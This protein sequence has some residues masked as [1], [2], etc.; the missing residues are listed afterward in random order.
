[1]SHTTYYLGHTT[2]YLGTDDEDWWVIECSCGFRTAG[3]PDMETAA[4]IFGEHCYAEGY[5]RGSINRGSA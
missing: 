4:D 3:L 1:M 5:T 2:Y